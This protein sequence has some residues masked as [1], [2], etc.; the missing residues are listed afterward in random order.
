MMSTCHDRSL[1]ASIFLLGYAVLLWQSLRDASQPSIACSDEKSRA[2]VRPLVTPG[3]RLTLELWM[4]QSST[5][6]DHLGWKQIK[7]CVINVTLQAPGLLPQEVTTAEENCTFALPNVSRI[8]WS[9]KD[10]RKG[11]PLH[12]KFLFRQIEPESERIGNVV[13]EVTFQLTR[14]VEGSLFGDLFSTAGGM[15]ARRNLLEEPMTAQDGNQQDTVFKHKYVPYLKY[16]SEPIVLRF[17]ADYRPYGGPPYVRNDGIELSVVPWNRTAYRPRIFVDDNSLLR[18]SQRELAPPEEGLHKPP[19]TLRIQI[20]TLSPIRDVLHQQLTMGLSIVES[21]LP[22]GELDEIRYWLRDERLY[23]F[24]LTQIISFVHLW[25]DY[26]AFRDEI[27]FYR[28]KASFAGV[29]VSSVVTRLLCSI[30]IF[31]Y[32]LDG[33]GTSWVILLSVF[34]GVAVDSWKAFKL[35]RPTF[36][37]RYPFVAFRAIENPMEQATAQYDRIAIKYLAMLLYPLVIGWAIYAL[38]VRFFSCTARFGSVWPLQKMNWRLIPIL[39]DSLALHVQV[40][41]LLAH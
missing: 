34:G 28:G 10:S 19:V 6:D 21:M 22:G 29:S 35:L 12:A 20:G 40:L 25:V 41:V 30:I 24:F 8:R 17:V 33:G 36:R 14:I 9:D 31:L 23:R 32:L 4:F 1:L 39:C 2:C 13:A 26:L 18:S 27:R 16:G 38:K 3:N 15:K 37:S 7:T 11:G 5:S